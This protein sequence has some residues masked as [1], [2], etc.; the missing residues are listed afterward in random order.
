MGSETIPKIGHGSVAPTQT[1]EA[2]TSG[3]SPADDSRAV[4]GKVSKDW[5][6]GPGIR[7]VGVRPP[8]VVPAAA[9]DSSHFHLFTAVARH[10]LQPKI[11]TQDLQDPTIE[12]V[13]VQDLQD[14][15][16]KSLSQ[17]P[18][19]PGSHDKTKISDPG[20]PVSHY[21]NKKSRSRISRI[22]R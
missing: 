14:P 19:Y 12:Y 8:R 18:R 22:P 2:V 6:A 3:T 15:T 7:H 16:A 20:S 17:D 4:S 11:T 10:V 5:V 21:S 9:K 13:K 1:A